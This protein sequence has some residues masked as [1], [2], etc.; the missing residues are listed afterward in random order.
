MLVRRAVRASVRR[1]SGLV[2]G[3]IDLRKG[4]PL[5]CELPH[6]AIA[7]AC[8]RAAGDLRSG[9]EGALSLNYGAARGSGAYLSAL[10]DWLSLAYGSPVRRGWLLSTGGVSQGLDLCAGAL[11][12]PGDEIVVE[13]PT[14]F[15]A[16]G[17][18]KDHGLVLRSCPVDAGGLDVDALE[19]ALRAGT[20]RPRAVYVV[21]RHGNPSGASLDRGRR[22]R[23]V[24]LAE[25]FGFY[26]FADE[27]YHLL[28]WSR[29]RRPRLVEFDSR[30]VDFDDGGGE[31]RG[32]DAPSEEEEDATYTRD[33]GGARGAPRGAAGGPTPRV[34]SVSS[35]TKIL[36]PGLRLGWIEAH[37]DVIAALAAR[38]SLVSGGGVAPFASEVAARVVR[39]GDLDAH[40]AKTVA[41]YRDRSEAM[42][43]AIDANSDVLEPLC[44]PTGGF[45]VWVGLK[46]GRRAQAL[47]DA[48]AGDVAFLCGDACDGGG[49]AVSGADAG[50]DLGTH[51]RLCFAM[52]APAALAEGVRRI[53]AKARQLAPPP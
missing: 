38:G 20:T 15:L 34:V 9:G 32:D 50:R 40:L 52:H 1:M 13:H 10:R 24:A 19:A 5:P 28:D 53:A 17:I 2:D 44:R 22:R 14:Y 21:P 30:Y 47:L 41:A 33:V 16:A 11:T 49:A 27:V 43:A 23:L 46:S 8:E 6:A 42:L 18:F 29:D 7:S 36:S 48:C 12:T 3:L 26:V 37:P 45:F 25:E 4:H 39:A 31:A 35:L 51:I